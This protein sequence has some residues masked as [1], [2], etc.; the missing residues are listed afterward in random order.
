M[1]SLNSPPACPAF[2]HSLRVSTQP[3]G[4]CRL[5]VSLHRQGRYHVLQQNITELT[6]VYITHYNIPYPAYLVIAPPTSTNFQKLWAW[7]RLT[8]MLIMMIHSQLHNKST[9]L[10]LHQFEK[11]S[12]CNYLDR[13]CNCDMMCDII[14]NYNF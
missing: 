4:Y 2:V 11:I 12:N 1:N 5:R 7:L 3:R 13:Y 6:T 9:E 10:G 8:N 14:G